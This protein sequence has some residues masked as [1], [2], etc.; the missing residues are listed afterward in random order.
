MRI[1]FVHAWIAASA[2]LSSLKALGLLAVSWWW[3]AGFAALPLLLIGGALGVC[4]LILLVL[5]LASSA[6]EEGA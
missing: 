4:G 5:A 3:V 6:E 2:L 1:D